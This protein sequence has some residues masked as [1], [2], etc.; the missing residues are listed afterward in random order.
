MDSKS[1]DGNKKADSTFSLS[2]KTPEERGVTFTVREKPTA[3]ANDP[4]PGGKEAWK[5]F[6]HKYNTLSKTEEY[7]STPWFILTG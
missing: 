1:K 4:L 2:S 3:K 5:L 7:H 6:F